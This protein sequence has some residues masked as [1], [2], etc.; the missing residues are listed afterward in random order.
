M[1][2]FI[3]DA[4]LR[5]TIT[6]CAI[7]FNFEDILQGPLMI[8]IVNPMGRSTATQSLHRTLDARR[9]DPDNPERQLP[10]NRRCSG[11]HV[12]WRRR[13]NMR[14]RSA[15]HQVALIIQSVIAHQASGPFHR[16]LHIYSF[17]NSHAPYFCL[18]GARF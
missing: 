1:S 10:R 13:F 9:R 17:Q 6:K 18:R 15:R 3:N 11:W 5:T 16:R 7:Y 14:Q 2:A 12:R 8:D 4:N